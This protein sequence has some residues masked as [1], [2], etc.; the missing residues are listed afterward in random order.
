MQFLRSCS[1]VTPLDM[2]RVL[3]RPGSHS[4]LINGQSS[5]IYRNQF[6]I[7]AQNTFREH[8]GE[9]GLNSRFS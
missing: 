4:L 5:H 2:I 1:V 8:T 9:G 3:F 7:L 6:G